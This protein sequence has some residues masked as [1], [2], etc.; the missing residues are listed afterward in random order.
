MAYV[1]SKEKR[2]NTHTASDQDTPDIAALSDGGWV[3]T[4]QSDGQDGSVYGI[5]AQAYHADGSKDGKET[6]VN[7]HT[8]SEQ[9][10]PTVT[11]L[12]HARFVISWKSYDVDGDEGAIMQRVFSPEQVHA[13]G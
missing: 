13:A 9:L 2:V 7:Q 1:G 6:R 10:D 8:N 11:A 3:V 5:Y 4:W 12:K